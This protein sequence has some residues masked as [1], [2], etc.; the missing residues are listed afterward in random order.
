MI[1]VGERTIVYLNG[2][3]MKTIPMPYSVTKAYGRVHL[4]NPKPY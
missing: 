3:I 4:R 2:H 1:I